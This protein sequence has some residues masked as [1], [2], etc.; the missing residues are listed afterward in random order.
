MYQLVSWF[1]DTM[2]VWRVKAVTENGLT[3][4]SREQVLSAVPCRI[5]SPQKNNLNLRT[6]AAA[7]VA[8]EKLAC[9]V[10]TDIQAGDEIIVTRGGALGRNIKTE[11]FIASRPTLYFDPVGCAATGLEHMEVGLHADNLVR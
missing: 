5:Y 3:K 2:D 8:D 6:D 1:T 9:P 10:D 7:V 4:Q 11:R